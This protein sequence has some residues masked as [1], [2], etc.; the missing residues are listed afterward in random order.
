MQYSLGRTIGVDDLAR[1]GPHEFSLRYIG[2]YRY[3]PAMTA[4]PPKKLAAA[5]GVPHSMWSEVFRWDPGND[6]PA[7][8]ARVAALIIWTARRGI[9]LH[10][11]RLPEHS[12]LRERTDPMLSARF[13]SVTKAAFDPVPVLDL[14][15]LLPDSE[16][17]DGEHA[18][19]SGAKR[20][21]AHVIGY[22]KAVR[23]QRVR[24]PGESAALRAL[25]SE[26]SRR[27]CAFDG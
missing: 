14:G 12:A 13:D 2:P 3:Q 8:R 22:L 4:M 26:W 7:I 6:A 5:L 15:C 11:V 21:S 16:F 27:D 18:L 1:E 10:V 17:L 24:A 25:A 20:T 9:E 19:W 23:Q